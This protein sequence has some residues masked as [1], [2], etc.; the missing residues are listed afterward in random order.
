[1]T[2]M[3]DGAYE[4]FEEE[5]SHLFAVAYRMLSS[6][7]E[8][9][10]IVQEAWLR[11]AAHGEP[12]ESPQAFLTTIVVR[13]CLDH[14][15]SARVRRESYVGPWLPEPIAIRASEGERDA[16]TP[17]S[18]VLLAESLRLAFLV[19]LER[20]T[21]L[22][23]AAFLLREVFGHPFD[24]IATILGTT[25]DACRKLVTRARGH[26]DEGRV[27]F[28]APADRKSE[29]LRAFVGAC[30]TGDA[31]SLERLLAA[32]VVARSDGGGKVH[33]APRPI[34]G[35]DRV[36]RFLFGVM[37]KFP[38][39]PWPEVVAINGELGVVIRDAS[40]VHA[41]V[42]LSVQG[43]RIADVFILNNPDKLTRLAVDLGVS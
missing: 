7:T 12:V 24:E 33:A 10:D 36:V 17:E 25:E 31:A 16:A 37:K 8:A 34:L 32:D 30:T 14:I 40:T 19:V 42:M 27:R 4:R 22:E 41:V 43:D 11:F 29:L 20:L 6:A 2:S 28:D 38:P 39:G 13:L 15:K 18:N 5:R 9:E 23:R 21:P 1:M 35:P 26:V 3:V